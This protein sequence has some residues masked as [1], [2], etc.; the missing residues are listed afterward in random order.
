V[1]VVAAG[2]KPK[3]ED[4]NDDEVDPFSPGRDSGIV[5]IAGRVRVLVEPPREW[6]QMLRQVSSL[7]PQLSHRGHR[8]SC[9]S[10]GGA[11]ARVAPDAAPGELPP[12]T[13]LPSW[14][15]PVVCE[16]WWSHRASGARCCAR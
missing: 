11:T 16:C 9:A 4:E 10:A 14:T 1:R 3:D 7:P 6:R 8:R 12:P 15:S 13:A 5:D 2:E